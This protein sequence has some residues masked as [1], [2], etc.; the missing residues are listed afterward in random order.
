MVSIIKNMSDK[1][2]LF[3]PP[4]NL[5]DVSVLFGIVALFLILTAILGNGLF[6]IFQE[7]VNFG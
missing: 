4:Y 7:N 1:K 5:K 2:P 6:G 3:K